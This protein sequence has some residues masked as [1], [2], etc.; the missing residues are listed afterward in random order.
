MDLCG[1]LVYLLVLLDYLLDPPHWPVIGDSYI[2]K[3]GLRG[4]FLTVY[5]LASVL[6]GRSMRIWP[7]AIVLTAFV[8]CLPGAPVVGTASFSSLLLAFT[9]HVL[10]MH[11][12]VP[13]TPI[14]LFAPDAALPL[15]TLLWHSVTHAWLPV[16]GFFLP[17]LFLATN[18]LSASLSDV[19]LQLSSG[20]AGAG[21]AEGVTAPLET[22]AAFLAL[23]LIVGL[24]YISSTA[25]L[26]LAFS[27]TLLHTKEAVR[28]DRYGAVVGREA[29]ALFAQAGLKYSPAASGAYPFPAPL[30]L[31]PLFLVDIPLALP[32]LLGHDVRM[33]RNRIERVIWRVT[34]APL[35]AVVGALWIWWDRRG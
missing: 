34:V 24:L 7:F 30:N 23:Y 4:V 12:P 28:W 11:V 14:F 19:F 16:L 3:F 31:L 5:A 9:L 33:I 18:L 1:N 17:A 20:F 15:A 13:P 25:T 26:V 35:A 21:A 10:C 6:S 27:S 2:H 32:R 22:R 29:R 8:V